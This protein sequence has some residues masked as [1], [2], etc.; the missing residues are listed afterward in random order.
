MTRTLQRRRLWR[1]KDGRGGQQ[2]NRK[3]FQ[4]REAFSQKEDL[5]LGLLNVDGLGIATWMDVKT[6]VEKERLDLVFLLE[7]KRREED[8]LEQLEIPGYEIIERLRSNESGD[9]MGGGIAI[10]CKQKDGL[11][12]KLHDPD[13]LDKQ[14][15]FV[16]KERQWV[17]ITSESRKTAVC[18]LY[19]GCQNSQDSY[20]I[21]NDIIYNQI[22]TEMIKLR[23]GGFRI[24]LL[25]DFN[26]H[27]GCV[28]GQ[29]IP[30]NHSEINTNGYR[31]L[32]FLKSA[33][34]VHVNGAMLNPGD[35]S[36]KI[37]QGLWTRQRG[38]RS[39]IL[40]YGVI[41]R[42]HLNTVV[43][44]KIDDQGNL[45]CGNSDHNWLFL[46]VKDNFVRQNRKPVVD[47]IRKSW[48]IDENSDWKSFTEHVN[49]EIETIDKTSITKYANSLSGVLLD[50]L[51]SVFGFKKTQ[52]KTNRVALPKGIVYE[53][54]KRKELKQIFLKA[55]KQW[56]DKCALS[57]NKEE[58][59]V[60]LD[61][62]EKKLM[63]QSDRVNNLTLAFKQMRRKEAAFKCKGNTTK[64]RKQFWKYVSG[65]SRRASGISALY[66]PVSG[67]LKCGAEELVTISENFMKKMFSGEFTKT[68][69]SQSTLLE[70]NENDVL[71][72][73]SDHQ[74]TNSKSNDMWEKAGFETGPKLW[75]C[76]ES[77]SPENDP[78]GFCGREI[79]IE[80]IN[81]QVKK[82][83]DGKAS[84]W[85]LI[86]NSAIK[87]AG[88]KFI[89]LLAD[90]YSRM[91]EEGEAPASW[92]D[93]RLVL[94]HKKGCREDI[95]MYR[96]LCVI[97][98]LAGLYSK[99][100][101]ERLTVVVEN[102]ALLGEIQN[103]FRRGRSCTD[104]HF[105]LATILWKA[106]AQNKDVHCGFVDL[107]SAYPTVNRDKLWLTLKK[108]GF[109]TKYINAIK[110]LYKDDK[111]STII[112]GKRSK[113]VY[114]TRGLKQGCSLSPLLFAL[115][116]ADLGAEITKSKHGF[117]INGTV[118]SGLFLADDLVLVAR[119]AIGLKNLL[120]LTQQWCLFKDQVMSIKKSQVISPSDL[121]WDIFDSN[122]ECIM[123]LK[124]VLQYRY[125]GM[126]MF[127]SMFKTG[128]TKQQDTIKKSS[129][130]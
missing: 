101:N 56:S 15:M 92:N 119:N 26:G 39:T 62:L 107:A 90:L 117:D 53:L 21:A 124:K 18:G 106:R 19:L 115:Y 122:G 30:G 68:K 31:L 51:K 94:V 55:Q 91:F 84:G 78:V 81:A 44:M 96:P 103:G 46:I 112:L 120:S 113:S 57:N 9:K 76:D 61:L 40:D 75:C 45:P 110:A 14:C 74:Y 99:V 42:E 105:I 11:V 97:V 43:S 80:E 28:L 50:G 116:A 38:G 6:S 125:L 8:V 49:K 10:L 36:T 66:D 69:P 59:P 60:E 5:R 104:S 85:D 3:K 32:S 37:T 108:Q 82:L 67:A 54:K 129:Q 88:K 63:D 16:R 4:T 24:I 2:E 93:G 127:Q 118:I 100:L 13:I 98:S 130:L 79:S 89:S 87:H 64:A 48:N 65:K 17:T 33:D 1:K 128:I 41:S 47:E 83:Q 58:R 71:I 121:S 23:K 27:I 73:A 114:L 70:E 29:G 95:N 22:Q 35:W 123:S 34:L 20:G 86:P 102:H 52:I 25:G 111:T 12:F 109:N 72:G 77:K 7:T 126:E